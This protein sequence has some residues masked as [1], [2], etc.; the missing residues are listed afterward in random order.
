MTPEIFGGIVRTIVS[1]ACG[2]LVGRGLI[3]QQ[4][5]LSVA[6]A[7]G[8]IGVAIWSIATKVKTGNPDA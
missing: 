6:S 2:Y 1:A 5:A 7:A 4:L 8:V 3:D